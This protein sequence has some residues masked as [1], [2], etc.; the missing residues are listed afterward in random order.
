ML[1]RSLNS[2]RGFTDGGFAVKVASDALK[3]LKVSDYG[4]AFK[5]R[6]MNKIKDN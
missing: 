3:V 5:D 6:R 2:I 1:N 4:R